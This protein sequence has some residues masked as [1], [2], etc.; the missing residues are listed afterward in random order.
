MS[1]QDTT[2]LPLIRDLAYELDEVS[3]T[4]DFPFKDGYAGRSRQLYSC[5]P[6]DEK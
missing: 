3:G 2:D 5:I 1:K 6:L 4:K